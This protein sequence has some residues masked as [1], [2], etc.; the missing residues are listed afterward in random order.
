MK[1]Y[2]AV[3]EGKITELSKSDS[4]FT[5][6]TEEISRTEYDSLILGIRVLL[7]KEDE[8]KVKNE[9][10]GDGYYGN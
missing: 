6:A 1:Y 5:L 4:N 2:K 10:N 3:T 8:N 7:N 9:L